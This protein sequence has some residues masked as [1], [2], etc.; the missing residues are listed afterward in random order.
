MKILCVIDTISSGGAQ[1]QMVH[2]A[3][4]LQARGHAVEV[5]VYFP[6]GQFFMPQL[7]AAKVVVHALDKPSQGVAAVFLALVRLMRDKRFDAAL[8]FL[9]GPSALLALA[10]VFAPRSTR[11]VLGERSVHSNTLGR[12][13]I[14]ALRA[15]HVLA[16]DIVANSVTQAVWLRQRWWLGRSKMHAVYN[17]YALNAPQGPSGD[18]NRQGPCRLLILARV[19]ISKNGARL[20]QALCQFQQKHGHVPEV[21]WAGRQERDAASLHYRAEIEAIVASNPALAQSW[22]WLGERSDVPA[23]LHDCDALLHVSLFEGLPN[24]VCEALIAGRPVIASDV[25]D[26]PHLVPE[27]VHGFLCDPLSP[28]SIC[29]AIE[30]FVALDAAARSAMGAR[31]RSYAEGHLGMDRMVLAYEKILMGQAAGLRG[32]S[33]CAA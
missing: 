10:S 32:D 1:K 24:A 8:G 11:L 28:E 14:N 26:H 19:D 23:L 16:D 21:R 12:G 3:C 33:T 13:K 6:E 25:C 29:A 4:G 20:A 5:F 30:R 18:A 27:G 22:H 2:L 7:Q 15:L 17:G 31:A 9:V